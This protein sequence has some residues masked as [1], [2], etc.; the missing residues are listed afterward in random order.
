MAILDSI[1]KAQEMGA[2]PKDILAEI[3][4]QNPTKA[5]AIKKAR[6]MGAG[7]DAILAE[8][9]KQNQPTLLQKAGN[10]SGRALKFGADTAKEIVAQ[11]ARATQQIGTGIGEKLVGAYKGKEYLSPMSFGG[12]LAGQVLS[13]L[14]NQQQAQQF[15]SNTYG[16]VQPTQTFRQG[17]GQAA[18]AASNLTLPFQANPLRLGLGAGAFGAGKTLEEGGTTGEAAL[19]GGIGFGLGAGLG[20]GGRYIG[21]PIAEGVK[22]MYQQTMKSVSEFLA[23]RVA[24]ISKP[25][26]NW[27]ITNAE[28]VVPKLETYIAAAEKQAPEEAEAILREQLLSTSK[29]LYQSA[30]K[31]VE[32]TFETGFNKLKTQFP[33]AKG[34]IPAIAKDIQSR[35]P[36]FGKPVSPDEVQALNAVLETLRSP[37][38]YT[39]EGMKVLS[40]ELWDLVTRTK[41]GTPARRAAMAGWTQVRDELSKVTG[42][43]IDKIYAPYALFKKKSLNIKPLWS[44]NV[45]ED[46]SRNFAASLENTAKGAALDTIKYL[47]TLSKNSPK[48]T[49]ELKA[50]NI[51]KKLSAELPV[52]GGSISRYTSPA[53]LGSL[54]GATG[55]GLGS[56][57]GPSGAMAGA[58]VGTALGSAILPSLL[59]PKNLATRALQTIEKP[60]ISGVRKSI[61]NLIQNPTLAATGAR[62]LSNLL[63]GKK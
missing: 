42:G 54:G 2:K 50:K 55:A 23:P 8:F 28:R 51:A 62:S 1:Q 34:N 41:Q 52:A 35:L 15:R 38:E 44:E 57:F 9:I 63:F 25:V 32:N 3:E 6:S 27:A 46:T 24:N 37:R 22:P 31:N 33:E 12:K 59:S 49:E 13:P 47:E 30:K 10:L 16:G 45:T 26:M 61:G 56:V 7:D 11:P 48:V 19:S 53:A 36:K 29:G 14:F 5:T 60:A 39:L 18:Q 40:N 20:L 17:V 58:G 4:R 21:K 43:A